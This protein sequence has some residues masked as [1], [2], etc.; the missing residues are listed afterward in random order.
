[1]KCNINR[2][3]KN[4]ERKYGKNPDKRLVKIVE[5]LNNT[6]VE[7]DTPIKFRCKMCGKCCTDRHDL[8]LTARD[9][10]NIAKHLELTPAHVVERYCDTYLGETSRFPIVRLTPVGA[11]EHCPLLKDRKCSVHDSKPAICGMFPVGR[12]FHLEGENLTPDMFT[13]E[14]V[15]YLFQGC[16]WGDDSETITAREWLTKFGVSLDDD[17]FVEWQKAISQISRVIREMEKTETRETLNEI[18]DCVYVS[19]YLNY[20]IKK[21]FMPQFMQNA[22]LAVGFVEIMGKVTADE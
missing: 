10:F 8:L 6:Q 4:N 2:Q 14:G 21:D 12:Y 5:N 13:K 22:T 19:L 3:N 7:L 17:F 1:M 9:I 20:D 18:L 11:D 15:K 16:R